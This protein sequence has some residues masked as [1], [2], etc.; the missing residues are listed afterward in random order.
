MC[1]KSAHF[2]S[3]GQLADYD[4]RN[5]GHVGDKVLFLLIVPSLHV[6]RDR[7]DLKVPCH[8]SVLW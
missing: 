5:L 7:G 2:F 8:S 3:P 4:F 6:K 1:W